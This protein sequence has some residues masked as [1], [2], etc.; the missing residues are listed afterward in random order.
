MQ[1]GFVCVVV[2]P[3]GGFVLPAYHNRVPEQQA[4]PRFW[5]SCGVCQP[6]LP[7]EVGDVFSPLVEFWKGIPRRH[8]APRRGNLCGLTLYPV[9]QATM[10]NCAALGL[11]VLS[12]SLSLS[13]VLVCGQLSNGMGFL[14]RAS[15]RDEVIDKYEAHLHT[16]YV[17]RHT[18]TRNTTHP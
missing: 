11:V 2:C 6:R 4:A 10:R 13:L 18:H 3:L 7:I 1:E 17:R 15:L 16:E 14:N 8:N 9:C 5:A 12:L